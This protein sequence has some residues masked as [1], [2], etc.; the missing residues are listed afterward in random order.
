M[1]CP[2]CGGT[3][4]KA[5][6]PGWWQC[7]SEVATQAPGPGRGAPPTGRFGPTEIV[8]ASQCGEVY[9]EA[10]TLEQP[11]S[12]PSC[13]CGTFAIGV[14]AQCGEP[15]CGICSGMYSG[16][17]EHRLHAEERADAE[18]RAAT[19]LERAQ[20]EEEQSR[21]HGHEEA[22]KATQARIA[23]IGE[24]LGRSRAG[25]S[26]RV[27]D[28]FRGGG[29]WRVWPLLQ[30][31]PPRRR[32]R[33]YSVESQLAEEEPRT[34][35]ISDQGELIVISRMSPLFRSRGHGHPIADEWKESLP[36]EEMLERAEALAERHG[37]ETPAG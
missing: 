8:S 21:R 2:S 6:A 3:R 30:F 12:V 20:E 9:S 17:R 16:K 25:G 7:S 5:I 14:C 10:S 32:D 31:A 22:L 13:S 35:G 18:A 28:S 27:H 33:S 37:A 23:S 1:P 19:A 26:I 11:P 4:R 15:V 29:K 36:W 24:A 34:V